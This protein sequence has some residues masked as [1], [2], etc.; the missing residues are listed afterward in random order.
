MKKL[1]FLAIILGFYLT[2][3]DLSKNKNII[4]KEAIRIRILANSNSLKDQEIKKEVRHSVEPYLYNLIKDA[5][6]V[7]EAK[8]IINRNLI[9]IENIINKTYDGDFN[10]NFGLN[11]FPKKEYRGIIYEEGYYDSLVINLGN[12]VGDNWWCIL[13]PPLCMLEGNQI[14]DVE[15]RS[16]VSDIVNKYF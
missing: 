2:I 7:E 3:G 13:F 14:D 6:T 9:N 8:I 4:P 16:L 1:L 5:K 15:Y 10:I 11:Y 12:A